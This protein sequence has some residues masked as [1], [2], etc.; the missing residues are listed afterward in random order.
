MEPYKVQFFTLLTIQHRHEKNALQLA[1]DYFEIYSTPSIQ[2]EEDDETQEV[3]A[4]VETDKMNWKTALSSSVLFLAL[5]PYSNE[6]HDL[7]QRIQ[8]EESI[9]VHMEQLPACRETVKLLLKQ[10]IIHYPMQHQEELESMPAFVEADLT[11]HWHDVFHR[12]I[13]QHNIRVVSKYY[14]QIHGTRL[15][16]LLQ[17]DRDR[18]EQEISDMVSGGPEN[19]GALYAKMDR[20][21]DIVRFAQPTTPESV[22]TD[23]ATDLDQLLHLLETTTHLIHKENMTSGTG[24]STMQ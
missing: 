2:E 16:Q 11:K 14:T 21:K 22:L 5:S 19:G 4:M 8:N 13:I 18:L 10:E 3:Q 17:L 6:Q 1:K 23:W 12:R 15:A 24:N 7:L 9:Q 20:P